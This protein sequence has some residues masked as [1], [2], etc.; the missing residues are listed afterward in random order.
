MFDS[1]CHHYVRLSYGPKWE[2]LIKG[3]DGIER[4]LRKHDALPEGFVSK[5]DTG[6]Q[7]RAEESSSV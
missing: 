7:K 1:P 6:K 3:I 5:Q 4:V 2:S